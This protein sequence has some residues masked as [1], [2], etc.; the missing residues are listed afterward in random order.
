MAD[1]LALLRRLKAEKKKLDRPERKGG[2]DGAK[3]AAPPFQARIEHVISPD[4]DPPQAPE[5]R[6]LALDDTAEDTLAGLPRMHWTL[7][8]HDTGDGEM[9]A[10]EIAQDPVGTLAGGNGATVWDSA[11]SLCKYVTRQHELA[12]RCW[13]G[14]RVLEL[15]SGVGLVSCVLAALGA[16]VCATERRMALPLLEHNTSTNQ[17]AIRRFCEAKGWGVGSV[18]CMEL[19]WEQ[20]VASGGGSLDFDF[21]VR[22]H[23]TCTMLRL[24]ATCLHCRASRVRCFCD[25]CPFPTPPTPGRSGPRV[26]VQRPSSRASSPSNPNCP[27]PAQPEHGHRDA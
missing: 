23:V 27:D 3:D 7:S 26:S 13:E 20:F 21:V 24:C 4:P 12:P 25:G 18:A 16:R 5:A 6:H 17:P 9:H 10:L 11:I 15:G 19:D 22:V 1:A 2:R 14:K 8:A